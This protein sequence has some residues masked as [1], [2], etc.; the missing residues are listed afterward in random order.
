MIMFSLKR[1]LQASAISIA[2]LGCSCSDQSSV[3]SAT[4]APEESPIT[5]EECSQNIGDHPCDFSFYDQ[6]GNEFSLYE[7]YGTAMLIDFSTMWCGYCQVAASTAQPTQ[8][9]YGPDGFL[10]V[11]VLAEDYSGSEVDQSDVDLWI[12]NFGITSAPVLLGDRSIVDPTA[13]NGY[14]ISGWPTF[15]MI[16][17]NMVLTHGVNGWSEELIIQWIEETLEEDSEE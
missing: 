3:N 13:Q 5:W 4:G 17:K 14:P 1:L 2:M 10:Y 9:K 6:H 16:D 8:D 15:V 12:N 7:N 11:T